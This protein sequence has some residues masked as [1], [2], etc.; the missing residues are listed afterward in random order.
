[1][2]LRWKKFNYKDL[3]TIFVVPGHNYFFGYFYVVNEITL[4]IFQHNEKT[5]WKIFY[6]NSYCSFNSTIYFT[7]SSFF[8]NLII[9]PCVDSFILNVIFLIIHSLVLIFKNDFSALMFFFKWRT[10]SQMIRFDNEFS[11]CNFL[12]RQCWFECRYRITHTQM[13][14]YIF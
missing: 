11:L 14:N 1:M 7:D 13:I 6:S 3:Y 2:I 12:Y 4:Q 9:F 5:F 8:F 10:E